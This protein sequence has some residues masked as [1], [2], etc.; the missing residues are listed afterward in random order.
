MN[1]TASSKPET[2]YLKLSEPTPS[3]RPSPQ[4]I[5]QFHTVLATHCSISRHTIPIF[6]THTRQPLLLWPYTRHVH[7]PRPWLNLASA[8]LV[9]IDLANT[10]PGPSFVRRGGTTEA[11]YCDVRMLGRG[12]ECCSFAVREMCVWNSSVAA[13]YHIVQKESGI[14]SFFPS[15]TGKNDIDKE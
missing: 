9:P 14:Y 12:P 11:F 6:L 2:Q 7:A 4:H 3:S 10:F 15:R 8:C 5:T 13:P 1:K